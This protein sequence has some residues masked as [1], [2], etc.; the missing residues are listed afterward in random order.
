MNKLVI[1]ILVKT[2]VI[3]YEHYFQC[4]IMEKLLQSTPPIV[5]SLEVTVPLGLKF[6]PK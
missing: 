4:I 5:T 2:Q 1:I 6:R 3:Q